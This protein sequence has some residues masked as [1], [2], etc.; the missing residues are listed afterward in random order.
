MNLAKSA[1]SRDVVRNG[2]SDLCPESDGGK[3]QKAR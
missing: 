3:G 2:T 1:L